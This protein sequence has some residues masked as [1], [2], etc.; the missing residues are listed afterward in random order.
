MQYFAR[1][2]IHVGNF[3]RAI[4]VYLP[5]LIYSTFLTRFVDE[6]SVGLLFSLASILAVFT[7]LGA[8]HLFRRFRTHR[9]LI[10]AGF[11]AAA[12]L[13][14]LIL[15]LGAV[16]SILFFITSWIAG[17]V[18][19]LALDVILEKI[20]GVKE[21]ATGASRAVFLT[22]SSVAV[23]IASLIIAATLTNGDY[24]RIFI[25]A[26]GAFLACSYL[27]A[28][29]FSGIKHVVHTNVK[30]GEVVLAVLRNPS[31]AIVMAMHFILNLIFVWINIYIPL[32]L[33]NHMGIPW[34]IIGTIFALSMVPF[35]LL[36]VPI[37]IL[38][39]RKYG[40]K[41]F[42]IGGL[43]I[44]GLGFFALLFGA[45]VPIVI[46][47]TIIITINV[48]G[49]L[50]E[51]ATESY[52]FKKVGAAD[53][54]LIGVF[55]VLRQ[56]ATIIGPII[57]SIVLFL[58]PFEYAFIVFGIITLLCIPLALLMKDTR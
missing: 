56:F 13:V 23:A 45:G 8:P 27:S 6:S 40:E 28:R 9:V 30:V 24:W 41:E 11:V 2:A 31:L 14:G 49:A 39:D 35:I 12:S 20:V 57:G 5:Y 15:N 10:V 34:S 25:I 37:G 19:A 36:Q 51:I 47:A 21:E 53:S 17:W 33:H 58:A 38:A 32:Y 52:F 4:G 48:G 16:L 18:V 1:N 7:L 22:A 26:A 55:R 3:L 43:L 46:L 50:L 42:I 29:F 54:E 44:A